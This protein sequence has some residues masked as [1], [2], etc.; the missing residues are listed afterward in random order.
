MKPYLDMALR[1]NSRL[2]VFHM[3]NQF[4]SI[5]NVP[6]F[7]IERMTNTYEPHSLDHAVT[8]EN[9]HETITTIC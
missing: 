3:Q 5:H 4:K 2:F 6:D 9:A 7:V 1:Y 8:Q